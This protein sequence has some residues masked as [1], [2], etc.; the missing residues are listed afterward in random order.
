MKQIS[1]LTRLQLKNMYGINV[2]RH[3]KDKKERAKKLALAVAYM[4][5]AVVVAFCIGGTTFGYVFLG[6]EE[7]VPAYLIMLC[8]L[9][10][11]FFSIFKA[12]SVIFQKNAYD[13]LSSLP[14]SQSAIVV[15]RFVRMYMENLVLTM[16][17]MVPAMVVYG[18]MVGPQVTFYI[19]G[20]LV[21][22]FIPVLPITL[23]VF[24]GGLIT[25]IS[26]RMKH[27][28]I[29]SAVL[30]IAIVI[31]VMA[32]TASMPAM[33]EEF[34]VDMLKNMS[35][36]VSQLIES[37]YP[38]AVWLGDAM[39]QGDFVMCLGCIAVGIV[40]L[41]GVICMV[42]V[43]FHWICRG[44][45][46]T[47]AKHDYKMGSLKKSSVLGAMYGR[48]LKRY[49]SSGAY[50]TNTIIGPILVVVFAVSILVMGIDNLE[51]MMGLPIDVSGLI[52]FVIGGICSIMPTTCSSISMEGKE[53][54]IVKS[55]PIRTKELLDGKL[56]LN[57]SLILP[58]Y[59][60]SE[61]LLII[62]LRPDVMELLWLIVIPAIMITFSSVFGL[63]I[64]L[65]LPVFNWENEV[66]V[67]KQSASAFIGGIC[68]FLIVLISMVPVMVVPS[69]F[70]HVAKL[71]V[72]IVVGFVTG[73]LYGMNNKI[74]IKAMN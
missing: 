31:G 55:L 63:F 39:L 15:S 27:K 23:S 72:C 73:M 18:V 74:D 38:P 24:I 50:V 26:S 40:L 66:Y 16:L 13:I 52:P 36:I 22:L 42:S 8:S 19:I 41:V 54:W 33:E 34:S 49:L 4:F 20:M 11:L 28:S 47:S 45:Y 6:L 46:S 43:K 51:S 12:G 48:E 70:A 59:V 56:L 71:V 57:L 65:K 32:C 44:L 25:A 9:I 2:F 14:V 69:E 5:V 53:W 30:S 17:V 61:V 1:I 62:A 37:I 67:V 64:N 35:G 21:T 68:G 60:V 10:I 3:T 7:L 29:V 58:F